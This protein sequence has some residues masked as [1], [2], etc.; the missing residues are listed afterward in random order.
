MKDFIPAI[1]KMGKGNTISR[2]VETSNKTT[3]STESLFQRVPDSGS[4]EGEFV[5]G[6]LTDPSALYRY[7]TPFK[8]FV[9]RGEWKVIFSNWPN[10]Y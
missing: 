5:G 9:L 7:P 3:S 8:H 10:Y 6:E 1:P 2:L 4:I